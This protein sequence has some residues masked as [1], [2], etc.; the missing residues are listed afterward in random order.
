M[1]WDQEVQWKSKEE[2]EQ[3]TP[4]EIRGKRRKRLTMKMVDSPL[5]KKKSK[6]KS[7]GYDVEDE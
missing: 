2:E 1:E 4:E 5:I 3:L 7:G 6:R